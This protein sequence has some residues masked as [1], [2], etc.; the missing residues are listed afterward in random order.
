MRSDLVTIEWIRDRFVHTVDPVVRTTIDTLVRDLGTAVVD[1]DLG[2]A[3]GIAR[4]LRGTMSG[5][6]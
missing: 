3:A 1:E 6:L 2:A 4:A 5:V